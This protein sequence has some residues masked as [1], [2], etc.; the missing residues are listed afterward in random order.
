MEYVG[1]ICLIILI[2]YSGYPDRVK[3][4]ERKLKK[5]EKRNRENQ[6]EQEG[7]LEMSKIIA[8][9]VGKR[10]SI[11]SDEALIL[12]NTELECNVLDVD[13]EW[14]KFTYVDKKNI[15]KTKILRIE[16]I[17]SVELLEDENTS[18]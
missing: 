17:D 16:A 11:K 4:L 10:C 14:I 3:T 7:D 2:F 12:G 9:L 8:E 1:W 18:V 13:E 15:E 5:F 6:K